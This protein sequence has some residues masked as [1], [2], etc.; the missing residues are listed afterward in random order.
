MTYTK[1][2]IK[3][4]LQSVSPFDRLSDQALE[5]T[6]KSCKLLRYRMGQAIVIRDSLPSQIAIIYEGQARLLGQDPRSNTPRSL[7]LLEPGE[8][9]G[10]V[11][12]L[13]NTACETALASQETLCLN[14]P[15]QNFLDLFKSEADF[16]AGFR[17]RCGL[18]EVFDL[19]GAELERRADGVSDLKALTLEAHTASRVQTLLAGTHQLDLDRKHLWLLSGGS[20]SNGSVGRR[21]TPQETLQIDRSKKPAFGRHSRAHFHSSCS[22]CSCRLC[23]S[24]RYRRQRLCACRRI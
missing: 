10:W 6:L 2:D 13:R 12:L 15:S 20:A 11:S 17:D 5:R 8:I 23:P 19:L 1:T 24:P 18:I 7:T 9:L 4:F 14:L 3:S 22:C 21:L 16:A